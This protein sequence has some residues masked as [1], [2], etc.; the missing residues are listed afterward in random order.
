MMTQRLA[1]PVSR[2]RIVAAG[3]A[4]PL[5]CMRNGWAQ[6][7]S[8]TIGTYTGPQGDF[9]HRSVIPKFEADFGCKVFQTQGVTLGQIA[10]M[11]AQKSAPTYS[12]MMMDDTGLPV[13]RDEDLIAKLP[14]D[15]IPNLANALPRFI[16][17]DGFAV[18]FAMSACAPCRNTQTAGQINSYADLWD[19]RY[20]GRMVSAS[21]K[22]SQSVMLLIAAAAIV[23]GKPLSEAQFLTDQAWDKMAALKPN[24][25]TL[26]DNS[27]TAILQLSQGQFD[28][29]GPEFSK[30]V[31]PYRMKGAAVDMCYP[32]E[33]AF[34]GVNTMTLVKN[35]PNPDLG[36]AFINRMLDPVVQKGL[37]EAT[38][39]APTIRGVT[40]NA[41][42][43]ALVMYP[44]TK[45][46]A[47]K[48]TFMD[49]SALNPKR[50]AIVEKLNQVF[51]T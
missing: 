17:N 11:R 31:L 30:T 38:F 20:R 32:K 6:G 43:A 48:L 18:A 5:F 35:A 13:A 15:K 24:I 16:L 4:A 1:M 22:F 41:E 45:M 49:W 10:L 19:P 2:R 37:A 12:V 40:L 29:D 36:A 42:T 28:I 44:E 8:I 46:D 39:A 14:A 7:K 9:I 34:A 50:G 25:Q 21:A 23:T 27:T 51:G 33:G 47:M 3:L 26:Y